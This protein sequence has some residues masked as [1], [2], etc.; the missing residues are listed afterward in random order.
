MNILFQILKFRLMK[1]LKLV[2][3][4]CDGMVALLG[5]VFALI[6]LLRPEFMDYHA[7]AVHETWAEVDPGFQILIIALMRVSGGGFLGVSLAITMLLYIFLKQ[8]KVWPITAI[9]FIGQ[10]ILIPTLYATLLVKYHTGANPPWIAA[11]IAIV[12]LLVAWILALIRKKN[13][14]K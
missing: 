13:K 7:I 1:T 5:F 9:F 6:Y 14:Q 10:S 8:D 3:I 2:I 12:I 11:V 4:I